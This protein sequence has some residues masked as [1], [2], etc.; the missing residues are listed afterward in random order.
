MKEGAK[1]SLH[2][3]LTDYLELNKFLY[4]PCFLS[5]IL[6]N[7]LWGI[8]FFNIKS[9]TFIKISLL[10]FVTDPG[11]QDK[12]FGKRSDIELKFAKRRSLEGLREKINNSLLS[13]NLIYKMHNKLIYTM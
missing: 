2:Q 1:A 10:Y 11:I 8:N 6:N 13:S 4:W 5:F 3:I 9:T 7:Y 12:K